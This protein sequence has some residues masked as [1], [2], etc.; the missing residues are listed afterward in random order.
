MLTE[1]PAL[2]CFASRVNTSKLTKALLANDITFQQVIMLAVINDNPGLTHVNIARKLHVDRTTMSRNLIKLIAHGW[3]NQYCGPDSR[4]RRCNVS[5]SGRAMLNEAK[6]IVES[7]I[8]YLK[9]ELGNKSYN[10]LCDILT[11]YLKQKS[12]VNC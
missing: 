9:L 5:D 6:K 11:S 12:I 1:L 10:Q 2:L 7:E 8:K 4:R 3:V